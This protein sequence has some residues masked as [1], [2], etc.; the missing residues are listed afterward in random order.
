[1]TRSE[2]LRFCCAHV[3]QHVYSRE[4]IACIYTVVDAASVYFLVFFFLFARKKKI[5]TPALAG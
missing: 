2:C 3:S 4:L 1:M 5:L